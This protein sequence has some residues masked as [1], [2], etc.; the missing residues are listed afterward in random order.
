M[1]FGALESGADRSEG[2]GAMIELRTIMWRGI[3]EGRLP[4]YQFTGSLCNPRLCSA[5]CPHPQRKKMR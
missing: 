2:S 4:S 5:L 1:Y 3:A